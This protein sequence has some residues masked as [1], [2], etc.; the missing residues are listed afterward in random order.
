M[1][2]SSLFNFG[3]GCI[4]AMMCPLDGTYPLSLSCPWFGWSWPWGTPLFPCWLAGA[5]F[6]FPSY[7][8]LFASACL[9]SAAS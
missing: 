2:F 5:L 8:C 9:F 1:L 3:T 7:P 6:V 4:I